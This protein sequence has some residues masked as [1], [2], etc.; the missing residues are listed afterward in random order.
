MVLDIPYTPMF[1]PSLAAARHAMTEPVADL[2]PR[3]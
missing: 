2:K 1:A 3:P